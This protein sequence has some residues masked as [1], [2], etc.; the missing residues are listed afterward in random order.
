MYK[1]FRGNCP[2]YSQDTYS[3]R[4]EAGNVFALHHIELGTER[5]DRSKSELPSREVPDPS[6]AGAGIT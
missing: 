1:K 3:L 6:K 4:P 2:T 5:S